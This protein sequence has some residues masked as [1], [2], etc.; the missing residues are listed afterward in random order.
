MPTLSE[1]AGDQQPLVGYPKTI[2]FGPVEVDGYMMENGEFRQSIR[3]TGKALGCCPTNRSS[4]PW[5]V[6][7]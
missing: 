5:C 7:A 1:L 2:K 4:P 3:S 6:R